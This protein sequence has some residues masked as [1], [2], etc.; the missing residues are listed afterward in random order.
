MFSYDGNVHLQSYF[1]ENL[2]GCVSENA[3]SQ[4]AWVTQSVKHPTLDLGS[5]RDLED[6]GSS[7]ALGSAPSTEPA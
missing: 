1:S 2:T 5:G 3:A 6:V 4:G 7:R